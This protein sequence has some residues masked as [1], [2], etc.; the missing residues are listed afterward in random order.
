[1]LFCLLSASPVSFI[2]VWPLI[3]QLKA[4]YMTK[5][6]QQ[7]WSL[8]FILSDTLELYYVHS[9]GT[10]IAIDLVKKGIAWWTDKHVKFR[11]PGGSSNL[12]VAFQ[13][14]LSEAHSIP[15]DSQTFL[16]R[17]PA[18]FC[19][20]FF[21]PGTTKPVNW[22]KPVYELDDSDPENNGFINED[23]IVWMRT[24]ALPTF[25]K[26]YRIIQKKPNM[27]PTL[28]S[29]KYVLNVTY[30]ILWLVAWYTTAQYEPKLR[31]DCCF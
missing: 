2:Q 25:R 12:T 19:L 4:L 22:R 26:L 24:A 21:S 31:C 7:R 11:N 6:L 10:W 9:N 18:W 3:L 16:S 17:W 8:R 13:G 1:M 30:S 23:L 27:A 5:L 29:G 14:D 15:G 28:P 20:A